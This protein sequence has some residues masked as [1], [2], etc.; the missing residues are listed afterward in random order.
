MRSKLSGDR[1]I[2]SR[3]F[4]PSL[5][6]KLECKILVFTDA[7]L[8]NIND[9]TGSVGAH[10][11]WLVDSE[12]NCC[13][14]TWQANKIKRVVRSTIAAEALSLLEG[15]EASYYYRKMIENMLGL[16]H[17][18]IDISAYTDNKSVVEAVYSTKMVDDKRLRVDIAAIRELLQR[19]EISDIRWCPGSA[20]LADCMTKQGSPGYYLLEVL[21]CGKMIRL[22]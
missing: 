7:S 19:N 12:G 8:G 16:A 6:Q 20:Q 18:T 10:I 4:F 17:K 9:G 11:I 13:P 22:S 1:D 15:L 2:K 3:L 21:Q 5:S 14:I